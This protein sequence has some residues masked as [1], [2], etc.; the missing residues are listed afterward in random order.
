MNIDLTN[1]TAI[2]PG[3]TLSDGVRKML[4]EDQEK[5]AKPIEEVAADFVMA[6]RPSSII[7]RAA[8]MEEVATSQFMSPHRSPRRQQAPHSGS[9]A[10][11]WKASCEHENYT[12]KI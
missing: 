3:P 5:S 10:A 8:S 4:R 12:C 7:R 9:M 11:W 6:K 2:L 1:K